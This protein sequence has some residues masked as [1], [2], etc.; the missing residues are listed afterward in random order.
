MDAQ[1]EEVAAGT[2]Q[3]KARR[4][5]FLA[6]MPGDLFDREDAIAG[7]IARENASARSKLKR[8]YRL[9]DE[10]SAYRAN[11]VACRQACAACCRMNVM[12][13]ALEAELISA[14]TG[15]ARSHVPESIVH[16][17][18]RFVGSPCPFL[19]A[20]ECSIYD[21]RPLSCRKHA[22]YFTTNKWCSPP[23][24]NSVQAPMVQF[25]GLDE[26]LMMVSAGRGMP[27]LADIR[28]FFGMAKPQHE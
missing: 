26:A 23:H 7:A 14:A 1:D 5:A 28:D 2:E 8:V 9:M 3:A 12:I 24:L 22:S 25:G 11:H 20:D 4:A 17:Q 27:V 13:T 18:D 21:S 6:A 19:V 15:K 16:P 10:I